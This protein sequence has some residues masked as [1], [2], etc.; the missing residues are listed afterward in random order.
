MNL[1]Q[2]VNDIEAWLAHQNKAGQ[3]RWQVYYQKFTSSQLK[4]AHQPDKNASARRQFQQWKQ[5]MKEKE[6]LA[7]EKGQQESQAKTA[8]DGNNNSNQEGKT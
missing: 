8:I 4:P 6:R 3:N 1:S 7:Q 5:E 2:E